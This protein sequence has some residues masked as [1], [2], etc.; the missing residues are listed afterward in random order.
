M[1]F[2]S[3]Q[4]AVCSTGFDPRPAQRAYSLSMKFARLG[5]PEHSYNP[6]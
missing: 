6:G 4:K 2:E 3:I 1:L 5:G